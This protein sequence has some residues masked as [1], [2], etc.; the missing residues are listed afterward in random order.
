MISLVRMASGVGG[1]PTCVPSMVVC[2][3]ACSSLAARILASKT[4]PADPKA[5]GESLPN[6]YSSTALAGVNI[7]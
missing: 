7:L 5:T 1:V 2:S 4:P 6:L 3:V